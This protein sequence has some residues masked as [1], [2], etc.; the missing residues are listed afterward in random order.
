MTTFSAAEFRNLIDGSP[1]E[2][3]DRPFRFSPYAKHVFA[4][5]Q[6]PTKNDLR[7]FGLI[8]FG[9]HQDRN[10]KRLSRGFRPKHVRASV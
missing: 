7:R 8:R 9:K 3:T 10:E 5:G 6:M 2:T 4:C 1:H